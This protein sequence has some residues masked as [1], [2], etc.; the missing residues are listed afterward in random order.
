M[1]LRAAMSEE[2]KP[3]NKLKLSD[4]KASEPTLVDLEGR[5]FE[6]KPVTV[7]LMMRLSKPSMQDTPNRE[8]GLQALQGT[9][10]IGD[11]AVSGEE[12]ASLN[13]DSKQQLAARLLEI[14]GIENGGEDNLEVLGS[15]LKDR[16][17][18][19]PTPA[20]F[21]LGEALTAQLEGNFKGI[22][23]ATK[24][25]EAVTS[26]LSPE[27]WK[28][29]E[30]AS[31]LRNGIPSKIQGIEL[32]KP[33]I[34]GPIDWSKTPHA[35]AAKAAET[36]AELT[37]GMLA[38]QGS[39]L[40]NIGELTDSLIGVALPQWLDRLQTAEQEAKESAERAR[41]S[42]NWAIGSVIVSILATIATTLYDYS[43]GKEDAAELAARAGSVETLL[44]EQVS[45]NR[46]LLESL[47]QQRA[48]QA[49][50]YDKL[51][52]KVQ[53]ASDQEIAATAVIQERQDKL[54]KQPDQPQ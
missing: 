22:Q 43:S 48:E 10:W 28:T 9:L 13:E 31:Q 36:T 54:S 19:F 41:K 18:L 45:V 30:L 24:A 40:K 21:G 1:E 42:L 33:K 23:L 29:I 27:T 5:R 15:R 20:G 25:I 52:G 12:I 39:M 38:A 4:L 50:Q 8:A 53:V 32:E 3:E 51:A 46:K 37:Q 16:K 35:R 26:K 11:E 44:Q 7:G 6:V 2:K 17:S 34:A 47:Q 14:S 49:D